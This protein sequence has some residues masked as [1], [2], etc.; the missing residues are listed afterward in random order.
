MFHELARAD[1][2]RVRPLFTSLPLSLA[3]DAVI[4]GNTPARLWA[5]DAARPTT[6]LMWDTGRCY[7][8][9]GDPTHPHFNSAVRRWV[10][11]QIVRGPLYA[12]VL[13][14]SA[15]WET[16]IPP[17]FTGVSIARAERVVCAL[18]HR[19]VPDRAAQPPDGFRM[20]PL[21]EPLLRTSQLANLPLVTEEISSCWSSLAA[22]LANGFG[23]CLIRAH[24]SGDAEEI[25]CWC[26]AEFVSGTKLGIGIETLP[27]YRGYGF[28]TLTAT[29]LSSTAAPGA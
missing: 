29:R 9:A 14:G 16:A 28:A 17:I 7:Y 5:D 3:I 13:Y 23:F 15:D 12:K 25:V 2:P 26:T 21:D 18:E 4:A 8:L 22:F 10:A 1:Y 6:A 19:K 20:A 24:E 11:D 27:A